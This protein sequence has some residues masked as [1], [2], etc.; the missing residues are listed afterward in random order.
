MFVLMPEWPHTIPYD[1]AC[2]LAELDQFRCNTCD[3]DSWGVMRDWL[4]KHEVS[5]PTYMLPTAPEGRGDI[6]Q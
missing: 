6:D 1:L 4:V 2:L 3:Q 5:A